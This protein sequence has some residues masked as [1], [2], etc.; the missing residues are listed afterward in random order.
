MGIPSYEF[1]R[2]HAA[3]SALSPRGISSSL[4]KCKFNELRKFSEPGGPF[5]HERV[6]F[7]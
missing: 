3:H 4:E 2:M 7:N 6:A 1:L 5:R